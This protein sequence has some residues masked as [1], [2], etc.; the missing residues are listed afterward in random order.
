MKSL[1][2]L[3]IILFSVVLILVGCN[4]KN[5]KSFE[6]ANKIGVILMH[7]KGGDT[8]WVDPLAYSLRSAGMQVVTPIMPW[9]KDRIYDKTFDEAMAEIHSYVLKMRSNGIQYVYLSG[10][11]LGSIAAAGY[12]A[13]YDDIR[14]IIL[15]APGHFTGE[16]GFHNM[17]IADLKKADTMI[18]AGEGNKNSTFNDIN[19]G[20]RRDARYITANIFNSW[21]SDK[22]PAEFVANMKKIKNSIPVLYLAGSQ[23][24]IPQTKNRE[25]AFNKAPQNPKSRF[26]IIDSAHLYVP[27]NADKVIIEWLRN[28]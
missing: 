21:F 14:G 13:R 5:I 26:V 12:A 28:L 23:D 18:K 16:L 2:A 10:H 24:R 11:S 1:R 19:V 6:S 25:Y 27:R 8:R 15:L 9:H 4:S 3:H 7:G 22:G 17:F 20:K